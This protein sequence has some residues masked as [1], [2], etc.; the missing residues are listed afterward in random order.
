MKNAVDF[1]SVTTEYHF[2][3]TGFGGI[4]QFISKKANI[5]DYI[6]FNT[7][8]TMN[9]FFT[10]LLYFIDCLSREKEEGGGVISTLSSPSPPNEAQIFVLGII[11]KNMVI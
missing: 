2:F 10:K 4:I 7:V 6:F 1:G 9:I 11:K 5:V 8:M 3:L